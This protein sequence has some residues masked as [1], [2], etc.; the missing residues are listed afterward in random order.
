MTLRELRTVLTKNERAVGVLGHGVAERLQDQTLRRGGVACVSTHSSTPLGHWVPRSLSY[1]IA[2]P[3]ERKRRERSAERERKRDKEGGERGAGT[4]QSHHAQQ[5]LIREVLRPTPSTRVEKWRGTARHSMV[6]HGMVWHGTAH[7]QALHVRPN[8]TY[9][10][11]TQRTGTTLS[12]ARARAETRPCPLFPRLTWR[13][14]LVKCS[15][16]RMTWEIFIV[17]SSTATQKL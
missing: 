16:A 12:E 10:T 8:G 7:S 4:T 5:G 2:A 3:R 17:A 11:H 9:G 1:S 6:W 13:R 14:V 15:S